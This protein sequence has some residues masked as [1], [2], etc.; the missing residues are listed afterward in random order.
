MSDLYPRW[1]EDHVIL[2]DDGFDCDEAYAIVSQAGL[3]VERFRDHFKTDKGGREQQVNDLRVLKLCNRHGWL[4]ATLDS[5]MKDM[6]RQEIA[7]CPHV[8]ILATAHNNVANP[9]EWAQGLCKIKPIIER[10]NFKKRMRPW[11]LQFNRQGSITMGPVLVTWDT[12]A[13]T[14]KKGVKR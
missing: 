1:R 13:G 11:F 9:E 14:R 10:H 8:G 4:L 6:H 3:R 7:A 12:N 2:L 5:A